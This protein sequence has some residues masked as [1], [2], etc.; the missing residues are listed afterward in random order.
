S[1]LLPITSGAQLSDYGPGCIINVIERR[2]Y[3]I[4]TS[5]D[6]TGAITRTVAYEDTQSAGTVTQ[7]QEIIARNVLAANGS[8][9]LNFTY[10]VPSTI[11]PLRVRSARIWPASWPLYRTNLLALDAHSYTRSTLLSP[12]PVSAC[13][14]NHSV[15][16]TPFAAC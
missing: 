16:T 4:I 5:G 10:L 7:A 1:D 9:G 15:S 6:N 14:R 3:S 13:S 12:L 11:N 8:V 2:I